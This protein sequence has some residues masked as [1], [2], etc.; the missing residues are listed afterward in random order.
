MCLCC[1]DFDEGSGRQRR[2]NHHDRVEL[3]DA[4][5][6]N[7]CIEQENEQ[8]NVN[9]VESRNGSQF[10]IVDQTVASTAANYGA[11]AEHFAR[12]SHYNENRESAELARN[13]LLKELRTYNELQQYT[14]FESYNKLRQYIIIDA[15]CGG[16]RDLAEFSKLDNGRHKV[17]GFDPSTEFLDIAN[18]LVQGR[19]EL[20]QT[21]LVE[22][23]LPARYFGTVNAIYIM[24]SI[25]HVPRSLL[26]ACLSKLFRLLATNGVLLTTFPTGKSEEDPEKYRDYDGILLDGERWG[27]YM[28]VEMHQKFLEEAG[29]QCLLIVPE[30]MIYHSIRSLIVSIKPSQF[31]TIVKYVE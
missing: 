6:V 15:A 10:S 18:N 23:A 16:G 9:T 4:N 20:Y 31:G 24:A 8:P 27:N 7:M 5:R 14:D 26:P 11:R 22:L 25:F 28:P 30:F 12:R 29:F 13:W 1:E 21:D 17:I 3:R 2:K 19:C